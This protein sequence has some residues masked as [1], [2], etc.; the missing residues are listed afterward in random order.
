MKAVTDAEK[1]LYE[2]S[3]IRDVVLTFSNGVTIT[4]ENIASESMSFEE[5]ICE[6]SSLSFGSCNASAFSIEI[7]DVEHTFKGENLQAT[8]QTGNY[9]RNIG[10][11]VVATDNKTDDKLRRK[12]VAYDAI[13]DVK[14]RD[15]SA[16]Y[17]GLDFPMTLKVFR[18]SFFRELGITQVSVSLANDN[19]NIDKTIN[20]TT[21]SALTIMQA[22]CEIN[23][24]FGHINSDG[25]F[26][27]INLKNRLD[28]LYPDNGLYPSDTAIPA[29]NVT[30]IDIKLS[31]LKY[32]DY[33]C[34]PITEVKIRQEDN[35][36]G[37]AVGKSGNTYV[38]QNNFLCYGK[39]T[40]ELTAIGNKFLDSASYIEYTPANAVIMAKPWF[41]LGDYVSAT[42]INGDTVIFPLLHRTIDGIIALTDSIEASGEEIFTEKQSLTNQIEQTQSQTNILTR[43]LEETKSEISNTYV[44]KEQAG[45][46][47]EKLDEN[48][49]GYAEEVD[50]NAQGYADKAEGNANAH[51][52]KALENYTT[53]EDTS[54]ISQKV[55]EIEASV[56]KVS[57]TVGSWINLYPEDELYPEDTLYPKDGSA[58]SMEVESYV[59]IKSN[60]IVAGL[61]KSTQEYVDNTLYDY[62]KAEEVKS[63]ISISEDGFEQSLKST[64][65]EWKEYADGVGTSATDNANSHTDTTLKNFYSTTTDIKSMIQ[66][67]RDGIE[68]DYNSKIE[69][70][71]T[72]NPQDSVFPSDSLYPEDGYATVSTTESMIR[73][74]EQGIEQ[75]VSSQIDNE[76]E[77]IDD[78]YSDFV[79]KANLINLIVSNGSTESQ[80][81]L[82]DKFIG[83]VSEEID[84]SGKVTFSTF[85]DSL[86]NKINGINSTANTAKTT[87]DTANNTANGIKNNIYTKNTTTIDGGKI[88]TGSITADKIIVGAD[89]NIVT[90][91]SSTAE[92]LKVPLCTLAKNTFVENSIVTANNDKYLTLCNYRPWDLAYGDEIYFKA[93]LCG[94]G[95]IT[96]VEV[97]L[98]DANKKNIGSFKSENFTLPVDSYETIQ[99]TIDIG[100]STQ[101][102]SYY[103]VSVVKSST[104]NSIEI[105]DGA[106]CKTKADG[107]LIVNGSI[108]AEQLSTDAIMS[109]NY[110]QGVSGAYMN[111]ANGSFDSRYLSWDNLGQLNSLKGAIGGWQIDA[112]GLY[113]DNLRTGF[114]NAGA[115]RIYAGRYTY[116]EALKASTSGDDYPNFGV[117]EDGF[118]TMQQL[119]VMQ[120]GATIIGGI[121]LASGDLSVSDGQVNV[122]NQD[123]GIHAYIADEGLNTN[124]IVKADSGFNTYNNAGRLVA[125]WSGDFYVRQNNKDIFHA[126]VA[127]GII[128]NVTF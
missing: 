122:V 46:D 84:I 68:L 1:Q 18:D 87:A 61:E 8:I 33:T 28:T 14:D 47:Y 44:T 11:F 49:K 55:D 102:I 71:G 90:I 80:W 92:S 50:K 105:M 21:I 64:T 99:T 73:L 27:Y 126:Y 121:S 72:L 20:P 119:L 45:K 88:T 98:F 67:S 124:G 7:R 125:G 74:S 104:G 109:R 42:A 70:L 76:R 53:T 117:T 22:I 111:L 38:I 115:F 112:N 95:E 52:D 83:M 24:C 118:V 4:N 58:S 23:A 101:Q 62:S 96:H 113:N 30:P 59:D 89:S 127:N 48:A 40:E 108:T 69:H 128:Y 100:Y 75:K 37:C 63:L 65:E 41:E 31:S 91:N 86:Q 93:D 56:S 79:Q 107:Q 82:T 32:Q 34:K 5:M 39:G 51:T 106:I 6:N 12:I 110:V 81:A 114:I 19:M 16:W 103:V 54:K 78:F 25:E 60:E 15:M 35:D 3:N 57:N 36:V 10:S 94:A 77:E 13:Y 2:Q 97:V 120:N 66:S 26:E 29:M 85:D 116:A 123:T 9:K 17:N 43:S